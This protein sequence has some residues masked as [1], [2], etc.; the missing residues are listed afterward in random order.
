M[1]TPAAKTRRV[2]LVD[3]ACYKPPESQSCTWAFV[4]QQFCSMGKL[5]ERNLDFMQKTMERSGMG[6]SSYLSEGLIKKPVQ[7]SLED[8]LSETRAAMFGAVRDLLEKTGLSG[9]DIGIL[10]VNCTVFC[11][12]PSLSAMIVHEFKLR[13]NV[14]CYSLQGMGCSA[15]GQSKM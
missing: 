2:Y 5:S 15:G 10:V 7:I 11:V 8:A 6:D 1:A 14:N 12:N 9:S 4:A 3:F 13:D